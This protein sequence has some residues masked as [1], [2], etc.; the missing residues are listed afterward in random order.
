MNPNMDRGKRQKRIE[1]CRNALPPDH[2]AAIFLLEPGKRPLR[3]E[4]WH[5]LFDRSATSFL[6][7]PDALREL[8]PYPPFPELLPEH[9]GII[10]FIRRNGLEAFAGTSPFARVDLDR[11]QQW[12]HLGAL[13]PV[14]WRGPIR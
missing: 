6:G 1:A 11:I 4:A 9:F 12:H 2:Q 10:A 14:G 3:L 8:R 7:L 5:H 13:I